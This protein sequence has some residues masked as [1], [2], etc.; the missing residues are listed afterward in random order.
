MARAPVMTED[1][2]DPAINLAVVVKNDARTAADPMHFVCWQ[3]LNGQRPNTS[4]PIQRSKE[5][6]KPRLGWVSVDMYSRE[7]IGK[8]HSAVGNNLTTGLKTGTLAAGSALLCKTVHTVARIITIDKQSRSIK[9]VSN[10]GESTPRAKEPKD[11]E[12][13][14]K[15]DNKVQQGRSTRGAVCPSCGDKCNSKFC[16]L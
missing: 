11:V 8:T 3:K 7:N 12:P 4:R 5:T 1:S 16:F 6:I 9:V 15:Q 2:T 14:S 13:R 10:W